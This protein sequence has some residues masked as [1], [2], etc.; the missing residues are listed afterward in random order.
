MLF[1]DSNDEIFVS[2]QEVKSFYSCWDSFHEQDQF[3]SG[4]KPLLRCNPKQNSRYQNFSPRLTASVNN[5]IISLTDSAYEGDVIVWIGRMLQQKI[6]SSTRQSKFS[7]NTVMRKL[8]PIRLLPRPAFQKDWS[9]TTSALKKN[10]SSLY[11][12]S[13]IHIWRCRRSTLCR[14]RWSPYH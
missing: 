12:L 13:L 9:F 5:D 11:I 4:K 14:S 10:Y 7:H 6:N 8:P 2:L 1:L 3:G